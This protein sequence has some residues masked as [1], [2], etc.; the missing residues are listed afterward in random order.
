MLIDLG[1]ALSVGV[2]GAAKAGAVLEEGL[3][4]ARAIADVRLEAHALIQLTALRWRT[5]PEGTTEE[6]H[7]V[8][9]QAIPLFTELG[10]ERGLVRS[11]H[12]IADAHLT[13]LQ[14]GAQ[15]SAIEQ[16]LVHARRVGEPWL[17][18]FV[19]WDLGYA[20]AWGSTPVDEGLRRC[21]EVLERMEGFPRLECGYL[22]V[23]AQ[24]EAMSGD[25]DAARR[26][27]ARNKELVAEFGI[28]GHIPGEHFWQVEMLAGDP[29][30]AEHTIRTE[31]EALLADNNKGFRGGRALLLAEALQAQGRDEEAEQFTAIAREVG[32][33]DDMVVQGH[34]R[35]VLAKI[36]A[37]RGRYDEAERLA[38]EA[39]EI[40]SKTDAVSD[41]GDALM[42]LGEVLQLAAR[43]GE[44]ATAVEQA[45]NLYERKGNV[46]YSQRAEALLLRLRRPT[47]ANI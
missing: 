43:S 38:R 8:G 17:E 12:A 31:Y 9:E 21:A 3:R 29:V 28:V 39:V 27:I 14:F 36:L 24:L 37:T 26:S 2:D 20:I 40:F 6:L 32:A 18:R 41:H 46:V 22:A 45:L 34:W 16:A 11:W 25:F 23:Q 13:W 10:D 7:R 1:F 15:K 19:I 5:D 42:S 30:A 33:S 47:P 4:V 44:A 35:R